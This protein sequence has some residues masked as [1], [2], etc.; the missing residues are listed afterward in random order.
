[1]APKK[2]KDR[3][4]LCHIVIKMFNINL[5]KVSFSCLTPHPPSP[6]YK[7]IKFHLKS[8]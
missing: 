5:S 4:L 1:M 8:S 2:R 3:K 7:D 6:I